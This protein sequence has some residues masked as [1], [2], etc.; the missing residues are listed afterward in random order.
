MNTTFLR[1][2]GGFDISMGNS[3]DY[4]MLLNAAAIERPNTWKTIDIFY[5][6]GGTSHKEIYKTIWSGHQ[7][8]VG[9]LG[10]GSST[11]IFDLIVTSL[12]IARVWIGMKAKKVLVVL[13]KLM[14]KAKSG[15]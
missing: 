10:L 14:V 7:I 1:S 4:H 15:L 13:H 9:S 8:R 6:A 3:A 11:T 2:L 12:Q 5:L